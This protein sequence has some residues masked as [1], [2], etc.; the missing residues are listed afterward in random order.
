M[1][2]CMKLHIL[3]KRQKTRNPM[4]PPSVRLE[5]DIVAKRKLQLVIEF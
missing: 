1:Q 3:A 2:A 5:G 4:S